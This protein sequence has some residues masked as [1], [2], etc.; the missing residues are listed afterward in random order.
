MIVVRLMSKTNKSRAR[1]VTSLLLCILT[2]FIAAFV[3]LGYDGV[4]SIW[5]DTV[6]KSEDF[7]DSNDF[8]RFLDVGQG[9]SVLFYSNGRSML[10]D[11]GTVN[12]ANDVCR[13]LDSCG[14]DEIDVLMLSHL[15]S[16][17][18][19]GVQRICEDFLVKN[20]ILPEM[21]VYSEGL[22][23]AQ[24]A[25][26]YVKQ[27][28]GGIYNAVQGMNFKVGEIEIT[29]LAS[30][31]KL[32]DENNRSLFVMANMG[33]K[34]FFFSG[35]AETKAEKLLLKES[36]NLDCD[37]LKL[38][39]HGSSTS[40]S[41]DLLDALTPQY[42]V[43]SVGE[44]NSYGHPHKEVIKRI[45]SMN[46]EYFKTDINGDVTFYLE[47]GKIIPKCEKIAETS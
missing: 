27:S 28:G 42:A 32:E 3:Y 14:I 11:T 26:N 33:G 36:L 46:I 21:S 9:D 18:T 8:I 4:I 10:L 37:V 22:S 30:F 15:H 24:L 29:V 2:L 12:S 47:N 35:D 31:G 25:M 19:G 7:D 17:H 20:L 6:N 39:H 13:A 38:A 16:D 34:K 5:N 45:E 43:I 23:S 1:S 41:K 44:D 40:N